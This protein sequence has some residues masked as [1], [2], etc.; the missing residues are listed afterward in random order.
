MLPL[1]LSMHSSF[2]PIFEPDHVHS[3]RLNQ[4]NL[5]SYSSLYKC[6]LA[7]ILRVQLS[8]ERTN[9]LKSA[10]PCLRPI[11]VL[12]A[13]PPSTQRRAATASLGSVQLWWRSSAPGSTSFDVAPP[14]CF[15][16]TYRVMTKERCVLVAYVFVC[17]LVWVFL[18]WCFLVFWSWPVRSSRPVW[19]GSIRLYG[20]GAANLSFSLFFFLARSKSSVGFMGVGEVCG[21]AALLA[22]Y[23]AASG[24]D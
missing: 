17:A 10:T 16:G 21:L 22:F 6:T 1:H 9:T 15:A 13:P 12:S 19:F 20:L 23:R 2:V 14:C 5:T 7:T 24:T 11:D 3:L 18:S 8:G 4:V